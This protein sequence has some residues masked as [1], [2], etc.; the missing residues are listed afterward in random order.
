MN[1]LKTPH[2]L[3]WN[4]LHNEPLATQLAMFRQ[5]SA[6]INAQ[7]VKS[8]FRAFATDLLARGLIDMS[9]YVAIFG[10]KALYYLTPNATGSFCD[11]RTGADATTLAGIY[12]RAKYGGVSE[13]R[14]LARCVI[15]YLAA[16]LDDTSSSWSGLFCKAKEEGE[17]VVMMTTGW[18][19]VPSTANVLYDIVVEEI[20]LTLAHKGLPT[21]INVKLPR[22]RR[23]VKIMPASARPSAIGSI[24]CR[25]M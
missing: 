12:S 24:L 17:S 10:G 7:D 20:N 6:Q 25:I 22:L 15:D 18:R 8:G 11:M 13:I 1:G 9:D 23:R 4:T 5:A 16:E 3:A 14:Y 19:N 2:S 21:I